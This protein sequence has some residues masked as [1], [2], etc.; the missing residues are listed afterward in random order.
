VAVVA[1]VVVPVLAVRADR[2]A[3]AIGIPAG[4]RGLGVPAR[5]LGHG[6]LIARAANVRGDGEGIGSSSR[7]NGP[8]A[9]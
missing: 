1:C 2:P 7:L 5:P 3:A 6:R 9:R 4:S 8:T